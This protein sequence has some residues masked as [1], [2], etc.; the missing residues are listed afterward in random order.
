MFLAACIGDIISHDMLVPS[1]TITQG[2][3]NVM[4]NGKFAAHVTCTCACTGVIS[5]GIAH[6]PLPAPPPIVK[7]SATVLINFLPAARLVGSLDNTVCGAFLHLPTGP[8]NV[9][10]GG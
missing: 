5:A 8:R 1:G 10:I 4:I 2:A 9:L 7:G 3:P 6:I